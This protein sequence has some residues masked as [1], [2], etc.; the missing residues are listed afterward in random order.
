MTFKLSVFNAYSIKPLI[1]GGLKK[2]QMQCR[3]VTAPGSR[4]DFYKS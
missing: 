2:D 3:V 4:K 1:G